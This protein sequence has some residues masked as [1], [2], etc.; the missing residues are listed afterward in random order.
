MHQAE[1]LS[2]IKVKTKLEIP[3]MWKPSESVFYSIIDGSSQQSS[4]SD[5]L[6]GKSKKYRWKLTIK[7]DKFHKFF[8]KAELFAAFSTD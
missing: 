5:F 4:N 2:M 1:V 3:V 7:G 6:I 8:N